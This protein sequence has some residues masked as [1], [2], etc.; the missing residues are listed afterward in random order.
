MLLVTVA[1][2]AFARYME[3]SNGDGVETE[4][5]FTV[6][7]IGV[8]VP[9]PEKATSGFAKLLPVERQQLPA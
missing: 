2:N 8:A 5:S 1:K 6:G 4:N 7:V 9:G 3:K